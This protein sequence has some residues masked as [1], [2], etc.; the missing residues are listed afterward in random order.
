VRFGDTTREE[1]ESKVGVLWTNYTDLRISVYFTHRRQL[2][3][4]SGSIRPLP[5]F[6]VAQFFALPPELNTKN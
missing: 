1:F 6:A 2:A 5:Y 3:N 4:I